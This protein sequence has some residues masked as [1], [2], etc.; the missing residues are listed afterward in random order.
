M[1]KRKRLVYP[2]ARKSIFFLAILLFV[3]P[4]DLFAERG[5]V[6]KF[7]VK[8]ICKVKEI[9]SYCRSL[10]VW[11]PYPVSGEYQH[12]SDITIKS[13]LPVKVTRDPER[14]NNFLYLEARKPQFKDLQILM[15]FD[16]D[17]YK[18][19]NSINPRKIKELPE[20]LSS[21]ETYL[22]ASRYAL[23]TGDVRQTALKIV[24][25]KKD[26]FD[27]LN[28][29]FDY[30]YENMVYDKSVA[31]CGTGDVVRSYNVRRGGCVD[32]HTLFMAFCY[33]LDIP[34]KYIANAYL[35]FGEPAPDYRPMGFHCN[36][37]IL[38][39]GYG[40]IPLD[41]SHCKKGLGSRQFY[42]GSLD[43][44]RIQLGEGR[45]IN[46]GPIQNGDRLPEID[47]KPH[48]EINGLPYKNIDFQ[49]LYK[50]A[51]TEVFDE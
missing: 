6:K 7:R 42:F 8:Y 22:K 35:P 18:V 29:L 5:E 23:I 49:A 12:I 1:K 25:E 19:I 37:E 4:Q 48:V 47:L 3:H 40:W 11:I 32:F 30:V 21:Y 31:G 43:Y 33:A 50:D 17:R 28:A 34:V 14:G 13:P 16:V 44:Y 46:L 41:I 27:K 51:P 20:D 24:A 45:N 15:E 9:P 2:L 39:P 38:L 26:Y 10:K 36:V